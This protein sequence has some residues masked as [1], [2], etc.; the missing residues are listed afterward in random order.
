[1]EDTK[2]W[3]QE[4]ETGR[5]YVNY[6]EPDGRT[7]R[8]YNEELLE[9]ESEYANQ[10]QY[11]GY[12]QNAYDP[13]YRGNV[14]RNRPSS[15][16]RTQETPRSASRQPPVPSSRDARTRRQSSSLAQSSGRPGLI[17]E[18]SNR[19]E[20]RRYH[21]SR[22]YSR[23]NA[24][25]E[26]ERLAQ[27]EDYHDAAPIASSSYRD[28]AFQSQYEAGD[29]D[30]SVESVNANME[31]MTMKDSE[32]ATGSHYYYASTQPNASLSMGNTAASSGQW[33]TTP[34]AAV[35]PQWTANTHQSTGTAVAARG[36]SRPRQTRFIQGNPKLGETE[37]LDPS[38]RIRNNDWKSFFQCGRVFKTL[39][40]D[41]AGPDYNN[42][43]END[44]FMSKQR[45]KVAYGQIV[46]SKI[47]RFIVVKQNDRSCQCLP[48]TTYNG[49]GYKKGG[50][51]LNAHG[52]IYSAG[53]AP[54]EVPDITKRPLKVRPAKNGER[55]NSNSYVNYGRVYCVDTN[56]KV[57][58]LGELDSDSRKLLRWYYREAQFPSGEDLVDPTTYSQTP[59]QDDQLQGIGAGVATLGSFSEAPSSQV[60][61]SMT[62]GY[63]QS[64]K[65]R[66]SSNS[67]Q[68][69]NT[70]AGSGGAGNFSSQSFSSGPGYEQDY[71]QG[72]NS[73]SQWSPTVE[74]HV[75]PET[76]HFESSQSDN[77]LISADEYPG[78]GHEHEGGF[79]PDAAVGSAER[80]SYFPPVDSASQSIEEPGAVDEQD[81]IDLDRPQSHRDTGDRHRRRHRDR[82]N[83]DRHKHR[84]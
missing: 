78:H 49:K 10:A 50:I 76:A 81:D 15:G 60:G 6:T 82:D 20:G 67:W 11:Q 46:Y 31:K 83:R 41:A 68:S 7:V 19:R 25:E 12:Q 61:A 36:G 32:F 17:P 52:L 30:A 57:K 72:A 77:I 70:W 18:Q 53:D 73:S 9:Q 56:V 51:N 33:H 55:V 66:Q 29:E 23:P 24:E 65:Y 3:I 42:K 47:R 38:F 34:S 64:G 16:R 54:I 43:S 22:G 45:F 79:A 2:T 84:R 40:T 4:R 71:G 13:N 74:S 37:E 80:E 48:V 75:S 28:P 62:S 58:D 8:R 14:D 59:N 27:D 39:W 21:D 63:S 26:E 44:Q 69:K 1:M 5:W 35:S